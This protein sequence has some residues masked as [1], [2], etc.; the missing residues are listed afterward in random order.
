MENA[1]EKIKKRIIILKKADPFSDPDH[2]YDNAA[3]DTDVREQ[4][5]HATVEAEIKEL[6]MKAKRIEKAI[7]RIKKGTYGICE[8]CK[9]QISIERLS[10]LPE[11]SYCAK[12]AA[13]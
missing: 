4:L 3:I 10:I 2:A 13:K 8:K 9:K 5:D 7:L 12:C 1:L 11:A 6:N